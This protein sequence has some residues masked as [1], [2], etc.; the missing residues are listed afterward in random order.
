MHKVFDKDSVLKIK[1]G[2]LRLETTASWKNKKALVQVIDYKLGVKTKGV[3]YQ[4][5][6]GYGVVFDGE[7]VSNGYCSYYAGEEANKQYWTD[8]EKD[9]FKSYIWDSRKITKEEA[10]L[11]CSIY[12]TFIY[13]FKK[14]K[15][16]LCVSELISFL[17]VWEAHQQDVE[18]LAALGFERLMYNTSLYNLSKVRKD[19]LIKF[20]Y[21]ASK[22]EDLKHLTYSQYLTLSNIDNLD[23]EYIKLIDYFPYDVYL[24]RFKKITDI[25]EKFYWR[26]HY[27][28]YI[29]LA[30][31]TEKDLNDSYWKYPK[32]LQ[33]LHD[34]LILEEKNYINSKDKMQFVKLETRIKKYKKY[35]AVVNGFEIGVTSDAALWRKQADMLHQC[36]IACGYY[37]RTNCLIVFITKNNV[38][39]ATAEILP[40]KEVGQFYGNEK[41]R[42]NC[43]PPKDAQTAFYK[44]L[45]D[46]KVGARI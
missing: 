20:L 18:M 36:I 21:K 45:K 5:I 17:K 14:L 28:D 24:K 33:E 39:V 38:P 41:Y 12:P 13:T 22:T 2:R 37:Q 30:K 27:K 23:M 29:K 19:R 3:W 46:V 44:W 9:V 43:L 6:A 4:N 35:N 31:K 1:Y 32:N 40:N 15:H 42:D 26:N 34:R 7:R 16:G 11:I 10:E 8:Y 25:E